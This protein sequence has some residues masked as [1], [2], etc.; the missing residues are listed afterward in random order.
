MT[1][2]WYLLKCPKGIET[3]FAKKCSK[4]VMFEEINEVVFFQYERMM[5]YAGRWHLEKRAL[6]PGCI[7]LSGLKRMDLKERRKD[8]E[9]TESN[10]K[11]PVSLFPCGIPYVRELCQEGDVI[12]MSQG[13]IREGKPLVMSGP[14]KGRENLIRKIDRHKRV[15]VIEI[16][17]GEDI[18]RVTIGLEIYG[19]QM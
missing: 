3:E 14:L 13:I 2:I 1:K 15:A 12:G 19:K 18:R 6:L 7:F 5:R 10:R 11:V 4:M 16:P 8:D 17:F 9:N